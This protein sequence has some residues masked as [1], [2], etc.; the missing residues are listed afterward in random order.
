MNVEDRNFQIV[1]TTKLYYDDDD[2]DIFL[3]F[4][5]LTTYARQESPPPNH[6]TFTIDVS[7]SDVRYAYN[8]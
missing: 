7:P 1:P 6:G 4:L 8:N 3:V 2:D 5:Q